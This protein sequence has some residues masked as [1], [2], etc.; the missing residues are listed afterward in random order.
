[1]GSEFFFECA[2]YCTH[3]IISSLPPLPFLSTSLPTSTSFLFLNLVPLSFSFSFFVYFHNPLGKNTWML[4]MRPKARW[5]TQHG[6][7]PG[8]LEESDPQVWFCTWW[9]GRTACF[10]MPYRL[11]WR[12]L[13]SFELMEC[14]QPFA[15]SYV[16]QGNHGLVLDAFSL[17]ANSRYPCIAFIK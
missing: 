16:T 3:L 11:P 17:I 2:L 9:T 10:S 13:P 6:G 8:W 7:P 4:T 15:L 12:E 1:M 14:T 5:L